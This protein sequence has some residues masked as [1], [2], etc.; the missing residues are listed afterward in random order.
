M[1]PSF[2]QDPVSLD[3]LILAPRRDR[4]PHQKSNKKLLC[5]FDSGSEG[6][7]PPEILRVGDGAADKKG[8]QI[9]VIPNLFPVTEIHEVIVHSPDHRRDLADLPTEHVE[10]IFKVFQDRYN[11]LKPKGYPLIFNN[12]GLEAGASLTHPHSQLTVIPAHIGVSSPLAQKPHNIAIKTK[13]LVAFCPDFSTWP[14]ETWI[15]PYPRGKD[16]GQ[17]DLP[18]LEELAK[19]TQQIL[20]SFRAAHPNLAYNF[21]IY[22][23]ADWYLRIMGRSLTKAGFEL[24]SGVQVNT[25]DPK[26]VVKILS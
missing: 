25:I 23:G 22:P 12:T 3:W 5:P 10:Q 1:K 15:E 11:A 14:Y 4:R 8:W 9:R 24:G 18:Q 21:Y 20:Q 16:F 6:M 7:T 13:S 2:F 26:E 19:L 17:V